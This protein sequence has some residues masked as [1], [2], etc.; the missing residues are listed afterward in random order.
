MY[1]AYIEWFKTTG[2]RG[3]LGRKQFVYRMEALGIEKTTRNSGG[4]SFK[5]V[6]LR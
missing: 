5:E 3:Q 4:Y 2:L 6:K 1:D